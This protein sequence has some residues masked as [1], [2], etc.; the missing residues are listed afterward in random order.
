MLEDTGERVIPDQMEVTNRLLIEHVAR[1]Q[2][3]TSFVYGRVLDFACGSG[4]GTH[5][6]IKS[7]KERVERVVGIDYSGDAIAYA[8]NRY[9]HP[10]TEFIHGDVTDPN[11]PSE[12]GQFNC[13]ISFETIEHIHDEKQFLKNIDQLLKPGGRLILSTPFG[14]GRDQPSGVPF[15]VHQLTVDEFKHLFDEFNYQSVEFFYQNGGLIVPESFE[16]DQYFPLGIAIC[17]K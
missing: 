16:V 6:M 13:I 1:Y 14:E 5:L 10:L 7:S 4:Y 3:A 2:F 17:Q 11:L 12:L 15:H 8:K 9:Y